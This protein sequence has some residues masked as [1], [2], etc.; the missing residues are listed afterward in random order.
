M[1]HADH[2]DR[3]RPGIPEPG[4][5]WADMGSGNG[6]FTLALAELI[7][8]QGAIYLVDSD[9]RARGICHR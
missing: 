6:A 9:R 7:G 8:K 1:V 2:V 5:P 4:G 3:L